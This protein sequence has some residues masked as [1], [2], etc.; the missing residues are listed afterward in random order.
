[1]DKPIEVL[2]WLVKHAEELLAV[3][4]DLER[5]G[6]LGKIEIERKHNIQRLTFEEKRLIDSHKVQARSEI[7]GEA[8]EI[9]A[10]ATADAAKLMADKQ[11]QL[12]A[13][14][15]EIQLKAKRLA[16]INGDIERGEAKLAEFHRV[17][18]Q[19]AG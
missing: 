13:V 17:R 1:M 4:P 11:Q 18:A 5:L 12:D 15:G 19:L 2:V 6:D 14:D 8:D 9:R 3:V 10:R 16:Q 7:A